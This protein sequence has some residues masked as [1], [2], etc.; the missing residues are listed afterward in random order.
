MKKAIATLIL[1]I[2]VWLP[3]NTARAE[4]C[5]IDAVPAATLLLPY[6]EAD[7]TRLN[8]TRTFFSINNATA[9]PALAKVILWTDLSVP[10]LSFHVYLTGYDSQEIDLNALFLNGQFPQTSDTL[11]NQGSFSNANTSFSGC[12][13]LLPPTR[14]T[15]SQI[16]GLQK[17][18]TGKAS[19]FFSGNCGGVDHNDSIARGY[20]TIDNVN[21]CS[22]SVPGNSG[23]FTD[24]GVGVANNTNQLWG[25]WFIIDPAQRSADGDNLV[26]IEAGNSF[27]NGDYTFYGRY[28]SSDGSDDREPLGTTWGTRYLTSGSNST[29]LAALA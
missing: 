14:L 12:D 11:S 22:T 9:A 21:L 20:I 5:T 18:H 27:N 28:V 19:S 17:A 8:G 1:S 26:H 24:G 4:L 10:T 7:I 23:Y 13:S 16:L 29:Y 2:V 25:D 6:F 3:H 15:L